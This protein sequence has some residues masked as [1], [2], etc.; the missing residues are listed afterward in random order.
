MGSPKRLSTSRIEGTRSSGRDVWLSDNDGGRGYGRLLVRIG[1]ANTRLFYYKYS[2]RGRVHTVPLGRYSR[3]PLESFLTL[4]Q[5]RSIARHYSALVRDPEAQG[6][7]KPIVL[8]PLPLAVL[9]SPVPA[10]DMSSGLDGSTLVDLCNSYVSHLAQRGSMKSSRLAACDTKNYICG[11]SWGALPAQA[12]TTESATELLRNIAD[13]CSNQKANKIRALLSA[14]YAVAK[15]SKTN[16]NVRIDFS[17]FGITSN[18]I[19]ETSKLDEAPTPLERNLS[20]EEV[21]KYWI[22]LTR[23]PEA[24]SMQ[25]KFLR[26]SLLLGGQ[27]CEQLLRALASNVNLDERVLLIYDLISN[28]PQPHE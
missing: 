12:F 4:E 22:A 23:W 7:N 19:T 24:A 6:I 14:A 17:P 16:A 18:P 1:R 8:P 27:R 5:A 3:T 21:G 20:G 28:Q 11:T 25:F 2:L 9:T 26:A 15:S 13:R 10:I